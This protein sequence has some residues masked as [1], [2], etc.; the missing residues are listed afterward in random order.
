VHVRNRRCI[1]SSTTGSS[2]L[3]S[4]SRLKVDSR[5]N[6]ASG[7]R[8]PALHA[9]LLKIDSTTQMTVEAA[10]SVP[11]TL[12]RLSWETVRLVPSRRSAEAV[13][14]AL[15]SRA[16]PGTYKRGD[17]IGSPEAHKIK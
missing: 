4:R 5:Q 2:K 3:I 11:T 10:I 15:P 8:Q 12:R 14:E 17:Q 1:G 16:R 6:A 9:T 7:I 13:M